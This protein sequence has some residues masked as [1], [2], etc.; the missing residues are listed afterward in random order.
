MKKKLLL[1]LF[2]FL[3]FGKLSMA[4]SR[5]P[6]GAI[7]D[8]RL[9]ERIRTAIRVL[10]AYFGTNEEMEDQNDAR[11]FINRVLGSEKFSSYVP[12]A[13]DDTDRESL[14]A[15]D[16]TDRESLDS[17]NRALS[18]GDQVRIRAMKK[19]IEYNKIIRRQF[20]L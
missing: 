11:R 20:G 2:I 7:P 10:N 3:T 14:L 5:L 18:S 19:G 8:E 13:F 12:L 4:S 1:F 9:M 15:F 6:N 16:D 17:Y